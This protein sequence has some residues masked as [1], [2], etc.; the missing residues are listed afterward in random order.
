MS[1]RSA[2]I[3][4]VGL[5]FHPLLF[6]AMLAGRFE[7]DF[8]EFPIELYAAPSQAGLL[9]PGEER[10]RQI[11]ARW[12]TVWRGGSL[13]LG[14]VDDPADLSPD[15]RI[16]RTIAGLFEISKSNTLIETI[17]FRR[18]GGRDL[19]RMQSMPYTRAAAGWV[20]A[21]WAAARDALEIPVL[22]QLCR[23]DPAT[24]FDDED[25]FA[26]LQAIADGAGC[27]FVFDASD[28][29]RLASQTRIDAKEAARR[30]A[31]L[32]VAMLTLSGES[33]E[34]WTALEL[35][36]ERIDVRSIVVRRS[37]YLFP[38]DAIGDALRR[39]KALPSRG[40]RSR[41]T[42]A[43]SLA[44]PAPHD[45]REIEALRAQQME[46]AQSALEAG[47]VSAAPEGEIVEDKDRATLANK[48]QSWQS[49]KTR[50][51]DVYKGQQIRKFLAGDP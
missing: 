18:V 41:R 36:R 9:D 49:W 8:V 26:F 32:P 27:E 15:P 51:D 20:A 39:A 19:G 17:G 43:P 10:L 4:G 42:P 13:S 2:E 16:V 5:G 30:I 1:D 45:F 29:G 25:A 47:L 46:L 38:I 22:L 6:N 50:L 11:V 14:S 28:L 3:E 24:R 33:E 37:K 40:E 7:C 44:T 21:R 23:T 35:L 48:T 31:E 34:D 12:P